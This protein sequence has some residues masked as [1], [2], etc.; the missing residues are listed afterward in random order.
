M[1]LLDQLDRDL[2]AAMLARDEVRRETIRSVK[3]ALLNA[4]VDKRAREGPHAT[5]DEN[6]TLKVIAQQAKQR[7]DSIAEFEKAGRT[8]LAERERAELAVLEEYL[9][10][11]AS[12]TEITAVVREV[13]AEVGAANPKQIGLVMGPAMERLQGRADGRTVNEVARDLLSAVS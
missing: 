4:L 13:I 6:E 3:T 7:R 9:P 5:L 12:M 1:A 10:Q 11:Q 2:K 8:D